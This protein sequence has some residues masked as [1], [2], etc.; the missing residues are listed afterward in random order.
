VDFSLIYSVGL[1]SVDWSFHTT[2]AANLLW[3]TQQSTCRQ[4]ARLSYSWSPWRGFSPTRPPSNKANGHKTGDDEPRCKGSETLSGILQ[5]LQEKYGGWANTTAI[6]K[7]YLNYV[8]T[9][10]ESFGDKVQYYTTFNGEI[11][12]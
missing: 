11:P 1:L 12:T 4:I 6:V 5:A 2:Q 10:V 3:F 8:E 9:V 7:D